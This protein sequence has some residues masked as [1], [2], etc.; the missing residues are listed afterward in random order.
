[1]R[2]DAIV[3][4]ILLACESAAPATR[5][6]EPAEPEVAPPPSYRVRRVA[7]PKIVLDGLPD[8]TGWG[9]AAVETGFTFPW[10]KMPAPR[11]EFRA[12]CDATHLYLS[13]RVRDADVVLR[14]ALRDE[15]GVEGED[16][17]EIFLSRDGGMRDYFCAEI[18]PPGRVLD[19]RSAHY[20]R[21]DYAWNW[22][23]LEARG[24][25]TQDGYSVEARIPLTGLERLGFPSLRA[26]QKLHC[27][28]YR[29]EFSH[30][31]SS[32]SAATTQSAQRGSPGGTPVENW[33][34]WRDPRTDRPDFHVPSSLGLLVIDPE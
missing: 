24:I 8:E 10:K 29:A 22:P 14:D 20:R 1:M 28:L 15:R 31:R 32:G 23:G 3:L 13:W 5:P 18:D 11:T 2:A 19:Y 7:T 6:S 34:S 33:I 17:V 12:I 27:G 16:R 30:P 26:G 25:R 21:F 4:M 9:P